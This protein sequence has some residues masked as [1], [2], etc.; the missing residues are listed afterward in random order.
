[1]RGSA[2]KAIQLLAKMVHVNGHVYPSS[3]TPLT[4]YAAFRNGTATVE[5]SKIMINRKAVDCVYVCNTNNKS[6]AETVRRVISAI[7]DASM[8][9]LESGSLFISVLPSLVIP[10]IGEAMLKTT[11]ET[12]HICDIMTQEGEAKHFT[13]ADH[14]YVLHKHLNQLLIDITLVNTEKVPEDY[15]SPEIY[16]KYLM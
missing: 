10:E 2:Y 7:M 14:M 12:I 9:I 4:L 5:E 15:M 13:D 16:D 8:A 3:E 6:E 1:M 11:A